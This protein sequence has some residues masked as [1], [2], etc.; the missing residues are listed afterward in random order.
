MTHIVWDCKSKTWM[1]RKSHWS[2][3]PRPKLKPRLFL[4]EIWTLS[5]EMSLSA[6]RI[7]FEL[8]EP[9]L[10][11]VFW[12]N[13]IKRVCQ[14]TRME[15]AILE[16]HDVLILFIELDFDGTSCLF[17]IAIRIRLECHSKV[18]TYNTSEISLDRWISIATTIQTEMRRLHSV[19]RHKIQ[20]AER[21]RRWCMVASLLT[22]ITPCSTGCAWAF[23]EAFVVRAW[24]SVCR[25]R[26]VNRVGVIVNGWQVV[27]SECIS[28]VCSPSGSIFKS[29]SEWI[30]LTRHIERTKQAP[31]RLQ[32]DST[33]VAAARWLV[34][35]IRFYAIKRC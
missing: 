13:Y 25:W 23:L 29:S 9:R 30:L 33:G 20:G 1:E 6:M 18:I 32:Q 24:I 35:R 5:S 10:K 26:C 4:N 8:V 19:Q 21:F 12:L 16:Q 14:N 7:V 31:C 15:S 3:R 11:R 22:L 17:T 2:A 27:A 28:S 34:G